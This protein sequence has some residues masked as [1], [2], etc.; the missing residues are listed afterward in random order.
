[1]I[2]QDFFDQYGISLSR[3]TTIARFHLFDPFDQFDMPKACM[4]GESKDRVKPLANDAPSS[5][6][7]L[8]LLYEHGHVIHG[9]HDNNAVGTWALGS[10]KTLS[11]EVQ[12]ATQTETAPSKIFKTKQFNC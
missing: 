8:S 10:C 5:F 6:G 1:M 11:E 7:M 12:S 9:N 2:Q 3:I 4:I